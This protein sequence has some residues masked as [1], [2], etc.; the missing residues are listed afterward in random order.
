MMKKQCDFCQIVSNSGA[1]ACCFS[2]FAFIRTHH[3]MVV[4]SHSESHIRLQHSKFV[5]CNIRCGSNN[6]FECKRVDL[7]G[8]SNP[9][10]ANFGSSTDWSGSLFS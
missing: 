4:S 8:I 9:G 7:G 5:V 6:L 1:G 2:N 10:V 3:F